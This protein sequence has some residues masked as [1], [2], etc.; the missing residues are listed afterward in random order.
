[1]G[2]PISW[3]YVYGNYSEDKT[4]DMERY[5]YIDV[6]YDAYSMV[7]KDIP[8]GKI[9]N[10]SVK[11]FLPDG[12]KELVLGFDIDV[13]HM[14]REYENED[15]PIQCFDS[16]LKLRLCAKERELTPGASS[17]MANIHLVNLSS[18]DHYIDEEVGD[19]EVG[20]KAVVDEA[21]RDE[22]V[23]DEEVRDEEMGEDDSVDSE[24]GKDDIEVGD[25]D[26]T[27][28]EKDLG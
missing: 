11:V 18:D 20:D 25:D 22:A 4:V 12:V 17:S 8:N 16:E 24:W 7:L 21:V 15:Q 14:F 10:F 28:S 5:G 13:L 3:I 1:M 26:S 6:V 2:D 23:G 19:E 9:L 27:D